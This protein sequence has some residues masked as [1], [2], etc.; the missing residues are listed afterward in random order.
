MTVDDA[1]GR[2]RRRLAELEQD[3]RVL[4]HELRQLHYR[5]VDLE[6]SEKSILGRLPDSVIQP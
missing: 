3:L 4:R 2:E 5:I 1:A 6:R